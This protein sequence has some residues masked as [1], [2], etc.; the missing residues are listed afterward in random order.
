MYSSS[1]YRI[2]NTWLGPPVSGSTLASRGGS[3]LGVAESLRTGVWKINHVEVLYDDDG[4]GH[5][6]GAT[7]EWAGDLGWIIRWD[8]P[9]DG[10]PTREVPEGHIR[11]F[12]W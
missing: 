11:E 8:Q 1:V 12:R 4:Q 7:I 6:Y 10:E 9:G 5:Y 2:P 3:R